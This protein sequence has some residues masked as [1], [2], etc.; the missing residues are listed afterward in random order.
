MTH[1]PPI[2]CDLSYLYSKISSYYSKVLNPFRFDKQCVPKKYIFL[3]SSIKKIIAFCKLKK[4]VAKILNLF[5]AKLRNVAQ[6]AIC[7]SQN[8]AKFEGNFTKHEIKNFVRISRNYQNEN[9]RKHPNRN[10]LHN[11]RFESIC[12]LKKNNRESGQERQDRR[13]AGQE[14]GTTSQ[15]QGRSTVTQGRRGGR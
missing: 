8:F 1:P 11:Y 2:K 6:I 4:K 10:L 3:N 9:F 13:K 7:V 5:F 14:G 12:F 15:R